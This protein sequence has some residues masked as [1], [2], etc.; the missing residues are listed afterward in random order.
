MA[1]SIAAP[2]T[3]VPKGQSGAAEMDSSASVYAELGIRPSDDVKA[4]EVAI[5]R[6]G[7]VMSTAG[8]Q[9]DGKVDESVAVVSGPAEETE[10]EEIPARL[11]KLNQGTDGRF[12]YE[13]II[14]PDDRVRVNNTTAWPWS[15]QGHMLMKFPN[16]RWYIGSGTMVNRHHVLTAGHCVYSQADGGWATSVI[17]EAARNDNATPFGSVAATRLLSVAGWTAQQDSNWDFGMLVLASDLGDRTGWYGVITGPDS[18]IRN[19]RVNV[20]GYPGDKGGLQLWTH[21]DVIK[22]VSAERVFYDI[23][24][25]G[26]QSGSGVW[27][28]WAGHSGEKVCAVHT[29]GSTSGNGA[30]RISNPKFTR[31]VEWMSSY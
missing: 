6:R 28:R 29:T 22:S 2:Q 3:V 21:A 26:G 20:S 24:T 18:L 15:V 12:G 9:P 27:S 25:V 10:T 17:F 4:S 30:T 1:Q 13:V 31:I 11:G 16:G 19:Y 7:D 8:F 23:D 5:G 14:G